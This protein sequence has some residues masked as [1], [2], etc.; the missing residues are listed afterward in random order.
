M[1]T[2]FSNLPDLCE[3]RFPLA[4]LL[5]H[6]CCETGMLLEFSTLPLPAVLCVLACSPWVR[7]STGWDKGAHLASANRQPHWQLQAV[8]ALRPRS[9]VPGFLLSCPRPHPCQTALLVIPT[10][11]VPV[12]I[13]GGFRWLQQLPHSTT[14]IQP[15]EAT[16]ILPPTLETTSARLWRPGLA[17]ST[18]GRWSRSPSSLPLS[19]G[20]SWVTTA[21]V[22]A[23]VLLL[24]SLSFFPYR[25]LPQGDLPA[26][27]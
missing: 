1:K 2:T 23:C 10:G 22:Q 7:G 6:R 12:V 13:I 26:G 5:L 19:P 3:S 16:E 24:V 17:T 14:P 9:S 27:P 8:L 25:R 4:A 20:V 21:S 11:L 15:L 18:S